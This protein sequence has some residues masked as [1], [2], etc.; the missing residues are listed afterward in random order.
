MSAE[1]KPR[2]LIVFHTVTNQSGRV[3]DAIANE[4]EARGCE[5]T[6]AM[7]EFTDSRWCRIYRSSR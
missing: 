3:A 2:V 5:A 7:I 1:T 6:K 4:L